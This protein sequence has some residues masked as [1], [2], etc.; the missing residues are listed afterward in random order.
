MIGNGVAALASTTALQQK[1]TASAAPASGGKAADFADTLGRIGSNGQRSGDQAA[2][3][4]T[5]PKDEPQQVITGHARRDRL[6]ADIGWRTPTQSAATEAKDAESADTDDEASADLGLSKADEKATAS[7][8]ANRQTKAPV[9]V[10]ANVAA[11]PDGKAA[12]GTDSEESV[13]PTDKQAE[14]DKKS[15]DVPPVFSKGEIDA[16]DN[17]NAA[18][19]ASPQSVGDGKTSSR[20]DQPAN[21]RTPTTQA[22]AAQATV[23]NEQVAAAGRAAPVSSN[24][25]RAAVDGKV[26]PP[27]PETQGSGRSSPVSSVLQNDASASK[28][29]APQTPKARSGEAAPSVGAE[30]TARGKTAAAE[31]GETRVR[32]GEPSAPRV[33]TAMSGNAQPSATDK[34]ATVPI[35][36]SA[37][38]LA[39]GGERSAAGQVADAVARDLQE[40]AP[41]RLVVATSSGQGRPVRAIS[42]QLNPVELGTVNVRLHHVDGEMRV[43]IRAE[44]DQTAQMLAR[45]SDAIRSALRAAGIQ[46]SEISV[47]TNR[48]E[49]AGQQQQIAGQN[50][51]ASGQQWSGHDNRGNTSNESGQSNRQR[52]QGDLPNGRSGRDSGDAGT[53]VDDGRLLI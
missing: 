48:P 24:D 25:G 42:L 7:P 3:S 31:A 12:E 32:S 5:P 13:A 52:S 22:S 9:D 27:A 21:D 33:S 16:S 28:P 10:I 34:P 38:P 29:V 39:T 35:V 6:F 18:Q 20:T 17:A 11:G 43:S 51:D 8:E 15:G 2:D 23:S 1:G 49:T 40:L 37:Q 14:A 19:S 4:E 26:P 30:V 46:T 53:A 44:S 47:T 41:S 50:R 36:Q 45:D